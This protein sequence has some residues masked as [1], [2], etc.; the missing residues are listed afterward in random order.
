MINL[1]RCIIQ[2]I[3]DDKKKD[4][5][6]TISGT[7]HG[8]VSN[9][10]TVSRTYKYIQPKGYGFAA[11]D[12][13]HLSDKFKNLDFIG[14]EKVKLVG[15]EIDPETHRI[16][17]NGPDRIVNG[18]KIQT[19]YCKTGK[20]CI[21]ECF[22]NGEY[23]YPDMKIEVPSDNYDEAVKAMK[24]RIENGEIPNITDPNDASNIVKKG[25]YTYNQ[26]KNIAKAGNVDSILFDA[27][28]GAIT[29]TYAAG[30]ST[31]ISFATSVYS[32]ESLEDSIKFATLTGLKVYGT[33]FVTCIVASQLS[34]VGLNS[35]L[36]TTTDAIT[37]IIG[38]KASQILVNSLRTGKNIYGAA[39]TKSASKLLRGNIITSAVSIGVLSIS[40]VNRLFC[41]KISG[42]QLF[43]NLAKTSTSIGGGMA[44]FTG[45]ATVGAAVGT[46][47]PLVG[48]VVG[49]FVGGVVGAVAGGV[50]GDKVAEVVLDEFIED[51]ADEMINIIKDHFVRLSKEYLLNNN[52]V[53]K[54][55]DILHGRINIKVLQDMFSSYD[56]DTFAKNLIEHIILD[57]VKIRPKIHMPNIDKF[58]DVVIEILSEGIV[59]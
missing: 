37:K 18:I 5:G 43:K 8:N 1:Y 11:E 19:K 48:N 41:G 51:D 22:K 55:I 58:N 33:T 47:I 45:G 21:A 54:I 36:V 34:R 40:D 31:V 16:I 35:A 38:T 15:E 7:V 10:A 25:E 32:G 29:S 20:A 39:A 17:K 52:E 28:T 14:K 59:K 9:G 26:A 12:A 30:I 3:M 2:G 44:G 57:V 50:V 42:K 49:G 23:R 13:N 4:V 24:K 56:K 53:Q 46:V 27:K 6:A